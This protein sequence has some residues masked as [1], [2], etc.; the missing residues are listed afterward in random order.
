[1]N[2]TNKTTSIN[3]IEKPVQ[4][5]TNKINNAFSLY[6]NEQDEFNIYQD[7]ADS[8]ED[9]NQLFDIEFGFY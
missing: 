9:Y 6:E 1:M 5:P 8:F 2:T 4:E 3:T 7:K